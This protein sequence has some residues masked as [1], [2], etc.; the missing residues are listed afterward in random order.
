MCLRSTS[1]RVGARP[2][3]LTLPCLHAGVAALEERVGLQQA[4]LLVPA[5]YLLSGVGFLFA[6]RILDAETAAKAA[7]AAP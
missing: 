3:T 6:E 1:A 4:M 7:E 5:C 2:R